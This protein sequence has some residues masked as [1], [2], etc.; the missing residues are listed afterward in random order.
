[1]NAKSRL[2]GHEKSG[3]MWKQ[4][5]AKWECEGDCDRQNARYRG[6]REGEVNSQELGCSPDQRK[7]L[8]TSEA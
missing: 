5:I 6:S 3:K 8:N 1:M 2:F 7:L 4:V